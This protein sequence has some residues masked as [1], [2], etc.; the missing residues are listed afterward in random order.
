MDGEQVLEWIGPARLLA[1]ADEDRGA[2]GT[3]RS[4]IF[5]LAIGERS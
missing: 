3:T 5:A 1:G 2:S 4:G